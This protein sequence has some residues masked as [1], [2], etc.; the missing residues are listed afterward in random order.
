MISYKLLNLDLELVI[1]FLLSNKDNR[2][3]RQC[4]ASQF[5]MKTTKN[6]NQN[7]N[8]NSLTKSKPASFSKVPPFIPSRLSKSILANFKYFK[9]NSIINIEN[10]SINHSY[11]YALKNSI[12][13]IAKIKDTFLKLSTQKVLDIH[14][15]LNNTIKK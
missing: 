3:F 1:F 7:L 10:K 12:K 13:N 11:T 5:N 14:K 4:I 15:V 9:K 2:S 6:T 8:H